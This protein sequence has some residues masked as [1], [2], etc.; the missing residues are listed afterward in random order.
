MNLK[1]IIHYISE[2]I[3]NYLVINLTNSTTIYYRS[4]NKKHVA[5]KTMA[6]S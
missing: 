3:T 1:N 2:I 6:F 5:M 4:K